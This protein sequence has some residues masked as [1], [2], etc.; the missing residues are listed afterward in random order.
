MIEQNQL[1]ESSSHVLCS[2]IPSTFWHAAGCPWCLRWYG[3]RS[4][5][6]S[7]ILCSLCY[8][9][10][11]SL[12]ILLDIDG[13]WFRPKLRALPHNY[14]DIFR[15][16]RSVQCANCLS[17]PKDPAV[18]LLCGAFVCFRDSCCVDE[19][20][21]YEVASV[22]CPCW[23]HM[24]LFAHVD[25][26]FFWHCEL[27]WFVLPWSFLVCVCAYFFVSMCFLLQIF[28]SNIYVHMC[29]NAWQRS[30]WR[31]P[32]IGLFMNKAQI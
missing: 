13:K 4:L 27:N 28:N 30:V 18:C 5:I 16:Y 26:L 2:V 25:V 7:L 23:R 1:R 20:G 11:C 6:G 17:V 8:P 29:N 15:S 10:C 9:L 3:V 14:Y 24:S 32:H 22:S 19:A 12:Q 31:F 21:V